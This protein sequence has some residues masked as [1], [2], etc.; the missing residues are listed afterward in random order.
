[1]KEKEKEHKM[2]LSHQI[3]SVQGLQK[4]VDET[5]HQLQ[6]QSCKVNSH[7]NILQRHKTSWL[8]ISS[9]LVHVFDVISSS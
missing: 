9:I 5:K 3:D 1:M 4:M 8:L 2:E 6:Q 7:A